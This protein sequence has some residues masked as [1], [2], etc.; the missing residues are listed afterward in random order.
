MLTEMDTKP[1]NESFEFQDSRMLA[2][3]LNSFADVDGV[4]GSYGG[5]NYEI[6]ERALK[7]P[8]M[9]KI[10]STLPTDATKFDPKFFLDGVEYPPILENLNQIKVISQSLDSL[11]WL[12]AIRLALIYSRVYGDGFIVCGYSDAVRLE[13]LTKPLPQNKQL[14]LKWLAVRNRRD[15][16][17]NMQDKMYQLN[18]AANS[19]ESRSKLTKNTASHYK[20][21]PSRVIRFKGIELYGTTLSNNS[22]FNYSI[23]DAL[24]CKLS[25]YDTSI[26]SL[27]KM[28]NSHSAFS[29]GINDLS[30]MVKSGKSDLIKKRF[31]VI[32]QSLAKIGGIAYDKTNEQVN[33]ISRNYSGLEGLVQ[34]LK[35]DLL[36]ASGLPNYKLWGSSQQSVLSTGG[37]NEAEDY[38]NLV[39]TYQYASIDDRLCQLL[40]PTLPAGARLE[41][42][43][44]SN[45]SITDLSKKDVATSN[46]PVV[47]SKSPLANE[48]NESNE[49]ASSGIQAN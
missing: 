21:H 11:T 12:D 15:I 4:T 5:N 40:K 18:T 39:N 23:V 36:A 31:D 19:I 10:V 2:G 7:N 41:V 24:R 49:T 3:V 43:F 44:V 16:V 22:Y 46:E 8:L 34:L 45:K 28:I 29:Y 30:V 9:N 35:D 47:E 13:D 1:V 33:Y 27:A 6:N 26:Q 37:E 48:A 14:T 32:L 38:D 42:Q 25:N 17:I 20:V